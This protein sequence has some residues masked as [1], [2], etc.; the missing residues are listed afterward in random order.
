MLGIGSLILTAAMVAPSYAG[1]KV[2]TDNEMDEVTAAGQPIVLKGDD[3]DQRAETTIALGIEDNAQHDLRALILNNVAGENQVATNMNI[4]SGA[5]S[6]R[7]DNNIT[8]SWGS[9]YDRDFFGSASASANVSVTAEGGKA[10]C[11]AG[12]LI[13]VPK[14]GNSASATASASASTP[15]IRSSIYADQILLADGDVDYRPETHISMDIQNTAQQGLSALVVNNV[16]GL[17]QV[18]TALNIAGNVGTGPAPGGGNVAVTGGGSAAGQ[19]N[20]INQFRG[21]PFARPN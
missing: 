13:C 5:G 9:T 15:N 11:N 6:G 14:A 1:K 3:I 10:T 4:A 20:I 16:S 18:A 21:T 19:G 2:I 8:Q 17:N 7:Q 12:A